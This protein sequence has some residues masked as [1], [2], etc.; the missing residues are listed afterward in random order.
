MNRRKQPDISFQFTQFHKRKMV[1]V[2]RNWNSEIQSPIFSTFSVRGTLKILFS[3][4]A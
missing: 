4:D 3:D 1:L 2:K